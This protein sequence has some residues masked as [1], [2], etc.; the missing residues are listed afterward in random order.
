MS[1]KLI[2]KRTR[3]KGRGVF[4][5]EDIPKGAVIYSDHLLVFRDNELAS[6]SEGILRE[7]V[8]DVN[9]KYTAVSLG[10]GSLINHSDEPNCEFTVLKKKKI[11]IEIALRDIAEGEELLHEYNWE[12]DQ[13]DLRS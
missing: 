3:K 1:Y 13:E 6:D 7:Y 2:V 12:V 11:L 5:G 8:F 10:Y 4:A 9:D